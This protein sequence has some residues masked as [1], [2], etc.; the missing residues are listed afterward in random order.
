MGTNPRSWRSESPHVRLPARVA[1]RSA[2]FARLLPLPSHPIG[3]RDIAYICYAW[4]AQAWRQQCP[5]RRLL[6]AATGLAARN[7]ALARCRCFLAQ[8][9]DL[10]GAHHHVEAC[11]PQ[12]EDRRIVLDPGMR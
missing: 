10:T 9:R 7:A 6:F 2:G 5:F 4:I 12:G 3:A 1:A 11:V 8:F